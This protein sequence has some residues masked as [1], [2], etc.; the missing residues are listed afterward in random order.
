MRVLVP[1]RILPRGS[2]D[3]DIASSIFVV[4]TKNVLQVFWDIAPNRGTATALVCDG[5]TRRDEID[6]FQL[7][8]IGPQKGDDSIPIPIGKKGMPNSGNMSNP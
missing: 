8:A 4:T 1:V 6:G 5:A 7:F 2:Y 3:Y